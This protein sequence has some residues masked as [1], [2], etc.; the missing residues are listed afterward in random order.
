MNLEVVL[1]VWAGEYLDGEIVSQASLQPYIT[2]ALNELEFLTVS[3]IY[4]AF[5]F[6]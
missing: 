3:K 4:P 2:D 6:N 5:C 1:A